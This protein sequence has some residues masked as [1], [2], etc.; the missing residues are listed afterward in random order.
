MHFTDVYIVCF[1]NVPT[2]ILVSSFLLCWHGSMVVHVFHLDGNRF[3]SHTKI[4]HQLIPFS[5]SIIIFLILINEIPSQGLMKLSV[6]FFFFFWL[7]FYV[8]CVC[9]GG[10]HNVV[11]CGVFILCRRMSRLINST[12]HEHVLIT[13]RHI[14][15]QYRR[16]L[17]KQKYDVMWTITSSQSGVVIAF[18]AD[19]NEYPQSGSVP[20]RHAAFKVS[21]GLSLTAATTTSPGLALASSVVSLVCTVFCCSHQHNQW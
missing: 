10:S 7:F 20:H 13:E 17:F 12:I 14:S 8:I 3:S 21:S 2:Y 1:Q 5:L 4:S 15:S 6:V 19:C 11:N 16:G 9:N 18:K